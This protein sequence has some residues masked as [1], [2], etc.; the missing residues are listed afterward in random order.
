MIRNHFFVGGHHG[1]AAAQGFGDDF[2]SGI[3]IIN[4]F[5]HEVDVFVAQ[6]GFAIKHEVIG[7]NWPRFVFILHT[8]AADIGFQRRCFRE[9]LIEPK[10]YTAETEQTDVK[11]FRGHMQQL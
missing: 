3:G 11:L 5:D 2:K 7:T 8:D 4:E 6:D 9:H 10:A 1:F